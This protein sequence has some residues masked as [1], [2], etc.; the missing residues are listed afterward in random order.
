MNQP[1]II[2]TAGSAD[3][4]TRRGGWAAILSCGA[5][6]RTLNGHADG[7]TH[8]LMELHAVT[9]ALQAIKHPHQSIEV[10]PDSQYLEQGIT[11]HV[12]RWQ[13]R[14]W[15]SS[16]GKTIANL[17]Q[18]QTLATLLK[19]QQVSATRIARHENTDASR[20]AQNAR[21][22]APTPAPVVKAI[23]QVLIAGSRDASD[24]M[25]VYAR[26]AVQRAHERGFM[27]IVGDNPH[28]VDMAVVQECRRL[29]AAVLIAGVSERPRNGGCRHGHYFQVERDTYRGMGGRLLNTYTVRDRWMVDMC[30]HALFIWNG[31]SPGTKAGYNYAIAREKDAHLVTFERKVAPHG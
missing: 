22:S 3:P 10:H 20:L 12:V 26:R 25:L 2:H 8:N 31:D 1:I 27:V 7:T 29:Q 23:T 11:T 4:Q 24:A 6:H 9:V 16:D 28:G 13:E 19:T 5:H 15:R 17:A 18:W 30:Q 21:R 14:D